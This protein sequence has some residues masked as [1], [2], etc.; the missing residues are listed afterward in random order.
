M[1]DDCKIGLPLKKPDKSKAYIPLPK[2]YKEP[3]IKL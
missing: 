3:R 2:D 1:D